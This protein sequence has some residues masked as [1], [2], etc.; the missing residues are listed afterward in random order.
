MTVEISQQDRLALRRTYLFSGMDEDQLSVILSMATP[1]TLESG[2]GLFQQGDAADHFFWVSEGMV[3]L[4]R[5]SPQGDEKVIELISPGRFFAEAVLFMGGRYPVNAV[6]QQPSRLI[7]FDGAGFKAWLGEDANRCFRLLSGMSAKLHK[8][9]N[10][11]D[12]LTLMKGSDRLMQY[13]I[14]HSEPDGEGNTVVLLE[15]PKQVIA[16]RIGVKP[17]TLSRLLQKLGSMGFLETR[18]SRVYLKDLD[19]LPQDGLE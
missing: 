3:R 7:A 15:A 10:E 18:G 17:E 2:Q 9:V 4:Y 16:S 11:I 14:D 6:C 5:S 19:Q 8:L 12:R 13:L 1:I